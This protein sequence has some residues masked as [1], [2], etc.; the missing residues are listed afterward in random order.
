MASRRGP[1]SAQGVSPGEAG[2]NHCGCRR[3]ATAGTIGE[4][5]ARNRQRPELVV[6]AS[7]QELQKSKQSDYFKQHFFSTALMDVPANI[8]WS[9]IPFILKDFLVGVSKQTPED[10]M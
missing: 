4:K 1:R 10:E 6:T 9:S 3:G 5:R 7:R 2:L 8:A